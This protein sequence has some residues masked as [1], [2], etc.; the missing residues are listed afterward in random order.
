[1][2]T[3][4]LDAP[5][6]IADHVA[7]SA[8][9]THSPG[10]TPRVELWSPWGGTGRPSTA[11]E[12][13]AFVARLR[14]LTNEQAGRGGRN[15]EY[16]RHHVTAMMTGLRNSVCADDLLAKA[17]GLR[18]DVLLA[19]Y[20]DV[21]ACRREAAHAWQML[22]ADPSAEMLEEIAPIAAGLL[23]VVISRLR[24]L[25]LRRSPDEPALGRVVARIDEEIQ[26]TVARAT[27]ME[28][29]MATLPADSSSSQRVAELLY[30]GFG[31][32]IW[33]CGTFLAPRVGTLIPSRVAS[34]LGEESV[35][36]SRARQR[37]RLFDAV[38]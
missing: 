37:P 25:R 8:A 31:E 23:P 1:M 30:D 24:A 15:A 19:A 36:G 20:D 5:A 14:E 9:S 12:E 35:A 29:T 13:A 2:S 33:S 34:L 26:R 38:A 21:E 11:R 27:E 17:P 7:L 4:T 32:G 28:A 22:V 18:P 16:A 6:S 3:Q 10:K